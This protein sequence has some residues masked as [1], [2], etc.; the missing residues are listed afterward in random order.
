M[1]LTVMGKGFKKPQSRIR[2][3]RFYKHFSNEAYR[4]SVINKLLQEKFVNND[5]GVQVFCDISLATLNKRAP[6]EIKYAPGNQMPFFDKELSKAIMTRT[7]LRNNFIQ[8]KSEENRKLHAKQRNFC[9]YLLRKM[10]KRYYENL[11]Y[12]AAF[13]F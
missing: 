4:E 3:Y 7:K 2:N 12:Y 9:V 13:N 11:R 1:T 6:R 5:N 10:K 8:N